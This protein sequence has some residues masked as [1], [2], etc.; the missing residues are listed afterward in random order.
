MIKM[1]YEFFTRVLIGFYPKLFT[2]VWVKSEDKKSG[3]GLV[4]DT[5][6]HDLK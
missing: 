4:T 6:L 5:N 3:F 2:W 1:T